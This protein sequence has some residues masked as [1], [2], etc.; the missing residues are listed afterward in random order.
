MEIRRVA[1]AAVLD[2]FHDACSLSKTCWDAFLIAL[3]VA[4]GSAH[5]SSVNFVGPSLI[6][7]DIRCTFN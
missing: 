2:S 4:M 6:I 1:T 3:D 5:F 7:L